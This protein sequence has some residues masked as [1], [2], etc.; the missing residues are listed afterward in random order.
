MV[1]KVE[2]DEVLEVPT[3]GNAQESIQQTEYQPDKT[4][5]K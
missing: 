2:D 4:K 5:V 3:P 1:E